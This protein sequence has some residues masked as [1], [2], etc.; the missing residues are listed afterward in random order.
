MNIKKIRA[1]LDLILDYWA[2]TFGAVLGLIALVLLMLDVMQWNTFM[3][4]MGAMSV[5]GYIPKLKPTDKTNQDNDN[6]AV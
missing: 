5:L 1:I 4:W 6:A 2:R 3:M